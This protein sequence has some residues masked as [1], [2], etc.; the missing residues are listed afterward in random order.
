MFGA[1]T[2][3]AS[4]PVYVGQRGVRRVLPLA[5]AAAAMIALVG[6]VAGLWLAPLLAGA[7]VAAALTRPRPAPRALAAQVALFAVALAVLGYQSLAQLADYADV[8]GSVVQAQEELG[9]LIGPLSNLEV[10]GVWL[11]GDYRLRPA[12]DAWLLNRELLL[13]VGIG[14]LLGLAWLLRRRAWPVLLY[15]VATGLAGAIV[16]ARGSPW[17]DAKALMISAPAVVLL[18]LLG[19]AALWVARQRALAV[20]LAGLVTLGVLVSNAL[21]YRDASI[22]PRDRMQELADIGQEIE[23]PTVFPAFDEFAK[24]FLRDARTDT[25]GDAI[26]RPANPWRAGQGRRFGFPA[27]VDQLS[28]DALRSYRTIVTPRGASGSRPPSTYERVRAGSYYDVWRRDDDAPRLLEHLPV[29]FG[30]E[31]SGRPDCAAVERLAATARRA[32]GSL[33]YLARPEAVGFAPSA[34]PLPGGWVVD[35]TDPATVRPVGPGRVERIVDV[36]AGGRFDL[37]IEASDARRWRVLVDGREVSDARWQ[38]GFRG[39]EVY[40]GSVELIAGNHTF[41]LIRGGGSLRAGNGDAGRLIGPLALTPDPGALPVAE[42][43]PS[44]WRELCGRTVDWVDAV[45]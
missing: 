34:A 15:V 28:D 45:G 6:P 29:G 17:A 13:V 35:G 8:A 23:G 5:V 22:A 33:R 38:I 32:G 37:W 7:L 43:S 20:L 24:Y 1:L 31:P 19:G 10:G 14:A 11:S 39:S 9:N 41:T 4:I 25:L 36:P 42:L 26:Q 21:L 12:G 44:R 40:L 30:R 3:A 18:A 27:D 16:T 2:V